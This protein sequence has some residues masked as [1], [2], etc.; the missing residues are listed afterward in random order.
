MSFDD[1]SYA[2]E[3][4]QS[5]VSLLA[6]VGTTQL[7]DEEFSWWFDRNPAGEGIVSLAVDE[8]EVVGVAAMSFFRTRLDG[9][10][11]RLAI[12]VNVATDARYRGQGVF[13]TLQ[14]ENEEAA[15]A[16][17][18]PLTV[19][20]PNAKSYPI[21]IRRL[22]G[23]LIFAVACAAEGPRRR[24]AG[25]RQRS[26][27]DARVAGTG[28]SAPP[29]SVAS[30]SSD[31]AARLVPRE[32]AAGARA[33]AV[34]RGRRIRARVGLGELSAHGR[35]GP[36]GWLPRHRDG[37]GGCPKSCGTARTASSCHPAIRP[38]WLR[39]SSASSRTAIFALGSP[40]RQR[41][42]WRGTPRTSSSRRSRPS[43]S[44]QAHEE[45]SPHVGRSR[46]S[47]PLSA[48]LEQKFAALEAELDVRV[49]ASAGRGS[50]TDPRFTLS[51]PIRPARARRSRLLRLAAVP[52]R[53]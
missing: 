48:S 36:R 47:L 5:L 26:R 9:T 35:R 23:T 14:A 51:R 21:F 42:R 30:V 28:P 19:T 39:Q 25:A 11:T 16:S 4:R 1:G 10:E 24:T 50:A 37:V 3:W 31:S 41:A 33:P 8:G 49:L 32:R 17:G 27:R 53:A 12:P 20:F 38:R 46:Y 7:T 43:S 2:P 13:S 22:A 40:R 15:A 34:P 6:R 45:A 18:S 29:S 52:G 44:G